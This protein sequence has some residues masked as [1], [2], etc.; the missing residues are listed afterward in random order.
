MGM[1]HF[2]L[3]VIGETHEGWHPQAIHTYINSLKPF[4]KVEMIELEEAH[5]GAAKPNVEETRKR[6]GER[7]LQSLPAQ[8]TIVVLDERGVNDAST[9]FAE[10]IAQWAEGGKPVVFLIGGSWGLSDEMR[11]K[12]HHLLSF[13]KQTLPHVLSRIILLEQLYRAETILRGKEYHK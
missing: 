10:R 2:I 9:K 11:K 8:A 1:H 4:A 3:R 12:A 6:E 7:L 5:R 13:G